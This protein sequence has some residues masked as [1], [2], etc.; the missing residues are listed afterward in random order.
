MS[1]SAA[2]SP[3]PSLPASVRGN[4]LG[5]GKWAAALYGALASLL[6]LL[7]ETAWVLLL[8]GAEIS[9]V[10][11]VQ[12]GIALLLP[13]FVALAVLAGSSG[14]LLLQLL[15][16]AERSRPHRVMLGLL[17][18]TGVAL[19]A[20]GVGGGRH[21]SAPGVRLGFALGVAALA[22]A[23]VVLSAARLSGALSRTPRGVA[24]G[25]A[26]LI[27]LLELLNRFAL[28]RL[29]PAFHSALAVAALL[30]APAVLLPLLLASRPP[31]RRYGA[32]AGVVVGL[33]LGLFG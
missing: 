31:R 22:Y 16:S 30:L 6:L 23:L 26:A 11:E 28:V 33:G 3:R 29:Y 32:R 27:V 19:A 1:V 13:A 5:L 10:W 2:D 8:R 18:A 4:L 17:V 25:A 12:T 24:A 14:G 7:L 21:L 20:F 15:T 9:S